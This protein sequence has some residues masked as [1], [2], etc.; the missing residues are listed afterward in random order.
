M[1]N[2][3]TDFVDDILNTSENTRR[4]FRMITNDDGTISFE[5]VTAYSQVGDSF[6]AADV[7]KITGAVNELNESFDKLHQTLNGVDLNTI[8]ENASGFHD[9]SAGCNV[10]NAGYPGFIESIPRAD[11][12]VVMHRYTQSSDKRVFTRNYVGGTWDEWVDGALNSDLD[13][14]E[15]DTLSKNGEIALPSSFKELYVYVTFGNGIGTQII[16]PRIVLTASN[17]LFSNGYYATP[18]SQIASAVTCSLTK[19]VYV[20]TYMDGVEAE[21]TMSVYYK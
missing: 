19:M 17:K 9:G 6:G 1:E 20:W 16:I 5:D 21:A 18:S 4:K 7:N 3:R 13:W 15:L 2:L 14:K 12:K 10:P 11:G 8:L